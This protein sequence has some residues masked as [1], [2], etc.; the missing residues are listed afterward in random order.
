[1]GAGVSASRDSSGDTYQ[2]RPSS[3]MQATGV[4]CHLYGAAPLPMRPILSGPTL[5][6]WADTVFR[7]EQYF[8]AEGG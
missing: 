6:T 8:L 5:V 3:V 7:P 1:M 4:S 2:A